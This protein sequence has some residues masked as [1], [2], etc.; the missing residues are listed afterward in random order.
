MDEKRPEGGSKYSYHD[1]F[2]C[3]GYGGFANKGVQRT[4]PLLDTRLRIYHGYFAAVSYVDS[5]VGKVLD[6][7]EERDPDYD[8][9]L[10]VLLGDH[11]F[12][13]GD[14]S[15]CGKHTI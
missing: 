2:E 4:R 5:Q 15:L 1:N 12:H 11:G 7:L 10:V 8:N 6:A 9:T 13:L 14:H 3:A